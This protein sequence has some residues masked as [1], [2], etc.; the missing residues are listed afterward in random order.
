MIL[1]TGAGARLAVA[2]RILAKS[3]YY[4]VAR[5]RPF[6]STANKTAKGRTAPS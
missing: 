3:H 2:E 5:V 1:Q 6:V 4:D